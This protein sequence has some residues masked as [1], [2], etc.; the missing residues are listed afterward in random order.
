MPARFVAGPCETLFRNPLSFQKNERVRMWNGSCI[1]YVGMEKRILV[2]DDEPH[3]RFAAGLALRRLGYL[4]EE[5]GNGGEAFAKLHGAREGGVPF[6]LLIT[7][8]QMSPTGGLELLD[9]LT[10]DGIRL[11]VLVISGYFDENLFAELLKR[12]IIDYLEKPLSL[13]DLVGRVEHI[14]Q[15]GKH[16]AAPTGVPAGERRV[17][18]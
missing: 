4:V 6:D 10:E 8:V 16:H 15:S 3:L 11:P 5:A 14:L 2:A 9:R 17:S 18:E 7:D 1:S 12:R 13:S